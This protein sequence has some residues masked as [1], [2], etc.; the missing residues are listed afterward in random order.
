LILLQITDIKENTKVNRV[1][2][3]ISRNFPSS[4][5]ISSDA[6]YYICDVE[7]RGEKDL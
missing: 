5:I 3:S 7:P 6:I 4:E 1:K 2:I